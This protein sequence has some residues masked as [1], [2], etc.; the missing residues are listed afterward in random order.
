MVSLSRIT[1]S[2]IP[3]KFGTGPMHFVATADLDGDGVGG[4]VVALMGPNPA[5]NGVYYY[6]PVD[7]ANGLFAKR[8]VSDLSSLKI[9][10]GDFLEDGKTDFGVISY[11]VPHHYEEPNPSFRVYYN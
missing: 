4:C 6:K 9:A 1:L 5:G 10:L 11:N 7:L 8:K 2:M 3:Q